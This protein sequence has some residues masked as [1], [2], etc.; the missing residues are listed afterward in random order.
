M[1]GVAQTFAVHTQA[2]TARNRT[3]SMP[4]DGIV[5]KTGVMFVVG[6]KDTVLIVTIESSFLVGI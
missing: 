4:C 1:S 2:I 5:G 6:L 3:N